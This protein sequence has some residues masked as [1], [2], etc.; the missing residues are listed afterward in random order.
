MMSR[1]GRDYR[2]SPADLSIDILKALKEARQSAGADSDVLSDLNV[3]MS[4]FSGYH[5]N[6]LFCF[7]VF[8][9]QK[10]LGE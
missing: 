2:V 8:Y 1:G 10:S 9:P 7:G 5:T 3:T 6:P 4:Q